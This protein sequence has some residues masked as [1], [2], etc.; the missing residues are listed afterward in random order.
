MLCLRPWKWSLLIAKKNLHEYD[1]NTKYF[2]VLYGFISLYIV[3]NLLWKWIKFL[4]AFLVTISKALI[5]SRYIHLIARKCIICSHTMNLYEALDNLQ[6]YI[7][8]E[9]GPFNHEGTPT[10]I[11]KF[12]ISGSDLIC[13]KDRLFIII[14]IYWDCRECG[15]IWL[16]LHCLNSR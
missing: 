7:I 14:Q 9:P 10:V 8:G 11:V 5:V 12:F 1:K 15:W 13:W 3:L 16:D 4:K 6:P 2:H